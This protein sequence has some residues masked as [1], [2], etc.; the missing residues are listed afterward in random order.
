MHFLHNRNSK[1]VWRGMM[2]VPPHTHICTNSLH[3]AVSQSKFSRKEHLPKSLA[4]YGQY[5]FPEPGDWRWIHFKPISVFQN[6]CLKCLIWNTF[7]FPILCSSG[8]LR[9]KENTDK[10]ILNFNYYAP[11]NLVKFPKVLQY[12]NRRVFFLPNFSLIH[13]IFLQH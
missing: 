2:L 9:L 5:V 12:F 10:D 3:V 13:S 8:V 4:N 7:L 6:I 11:L 1:L